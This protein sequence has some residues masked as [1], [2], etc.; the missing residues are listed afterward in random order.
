MIFRRKGK[1]VSKTV[2]RMILRRKGRLVSRTVRILIF[3]FQTVLNR[4]FKSAE[5]GSQFSVDSIG[6]SVSL[7]LTSLFVQ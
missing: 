1:L 4:N 5:A 3:R 7:L 2:Q 6:L